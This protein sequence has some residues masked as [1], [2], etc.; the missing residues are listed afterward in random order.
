MRVRPHR[1]ETCTP[2]LGPEPDPGA[3]R[4]QMQLTARDTTRPEPPLVEGPR[5]HKLRPTTHPMGLDTP[6]RRQRGVPG[7]RHGAHMR[8]P[9]HTTPTEWPVAPTRRVA[10]VAS[11]SLPSSIHLRA[12]GPG[13]RT[14]APARSARLSR[15]G[16][17]LAPARRRR[18]S[19]GRRRSGN[20]Q[21]RWSSVPRTGWRTPLPR[22]RAPTLTGEQG[23]ERP[24]MA[25]DVQ[26]LSSQ[27][28]SDA[29]A[30]ALIT[31]WLRGWLASGTKNESNV[32]CA[33]Q[34]HRGK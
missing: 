28:L 27:K 6:T 2:G 7:P 13:P 34:I 5:L 12:E 33:D 10:A 21:R 16:P 30:C 14:P 25:I 24:P 20:R 4:A 8:I 15:G 23:R 3:L 19:G 18:T 11:R 26:G 32:S 22:S 9:R 29:G 1:P 17:L 31:Q